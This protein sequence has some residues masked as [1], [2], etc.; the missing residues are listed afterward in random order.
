MQSQIF[1]RVM[2]GT[3]STYGTAVTRDTVLPKIRSASPVQVINKTYDASVGEGANVVAS[4]K[5]GIDAGGNNNLWMTPSGNDFLQFFVGPITGAGTSGDPYVVTEAT[6]IT[7]YSFSCEMSNAQSS[8]NSGF[9]LSGC[10][11]NTFSISGSVGSTI[12]FDSSFVAQKGV[13]LSTITSYT[14]VSEEPYVMVGGTF[15]YGGS[16]LSGVRA[17][18]YN[19]SNGLLSGDDTRNADT[20]FI[21]KPAMGVRTHSGEVSVKM[22]SSIATSIIADY[23]GQTATSGPVDDGAT[24]TGK[25]LN[26]TFKRGSERLQIYLD[27]VTID[28]V[29]VVYDLAQGIV[30]ITFPFTARY[31]KDNKPI[32]WW[33][34]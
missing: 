25:E 32:R 31:G 21:E 22:S 1:S 9:L 23:Y 18:T 3:E 27:E 29:P 28:D 6:D 12:T 24:I 30:I 16:T 10:V 17:F 2:Y 4:N 14:K 34:V 13:F 20:L 8:A 7:D 11:G 15:L 19:F 26:F 33:S 5:T